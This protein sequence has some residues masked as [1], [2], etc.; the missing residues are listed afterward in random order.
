MKSYK[1][2]IM[3]LGYV[4]GLP[5]AHVCSSKYKVVGFEIVKW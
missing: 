4:G 2:C 3:G 5:L 1:I